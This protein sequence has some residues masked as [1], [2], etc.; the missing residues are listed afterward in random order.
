MAALAA[1][2]GSTVGHDASVK[3][4]NPGTAPVS[5]SASSSPSGTVTIGSTNFPEQ[6]IV[7]NL[8]ADALEKAGIKTNLRVNLGTRKAVEPALAA[9]ALDLYPDYA[10]S[11]LIYLVPS[12]TAKATQLSTDIPALQKALGKHGAEVLK[13]APAV[14]QNVF[15]VTKQTAAKYHLTTLSSLKRVAG[16]LTLGAPPECPSYYYC[17]PGLEKV[18][19][20]HFRNVVSTDE[21]GPVTVAYLRNGRVQVAELFSSDGAIAEYGFVQLVDNKHLQPADHVIPVIR[22]SVASTTVV[23]AINA[24]SAKLTTA[25]LRK[26]NLEVSN[27]HK[28]PAA[29]AAAWFK[30]EHL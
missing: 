6:V 29:V 8:Y 30:A 1:G 26:L 10:G 19:G 20:I 5:S 23:K 17:L 18:Y 2:C 24:V 28:N 21:S 27:S 7:A 3:S 11:L 15:A 14:D 12:D 16:K 4:R 25:Q 22:K 13:P 9:G